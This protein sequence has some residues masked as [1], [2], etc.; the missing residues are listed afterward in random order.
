MTFGFE[1][2]LDGHEKI[3]RALNCLNETTARLLQDKGG[4]FVQRCALVF[5]ELLKEGI[6][7]EKY[8]QGTSVSG[9][10]PSYSEQ[11]KKW[12]GS[13][14]GWLK[15]SGKL[16]AS[17]THFP[18]NKGWMAGI[19]RGIYDENG[20]SVAYRGFLHEFGSPGHKIPQRP[21]IRPAVPDFVVTKWPAL[22]QEA[23]N[24]LRKVWR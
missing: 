19:P 1:I 22:R 24:E 13:Q 7:S 23:V 9:A 16:M 11:Y 12:K 20:N 18:F 14:G 15:L 17:I 2:K 10:Y 3:I 6:A 21:W 8:A 5:A 4:Q